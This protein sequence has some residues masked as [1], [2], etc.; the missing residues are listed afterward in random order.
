MKICVGFLSS[1]SYEL[2]IASTFL[3]PRALLYTQPLYWATCNASLLTVL[4]AS[5][6]NKENA[7]LSLF[8]FIERV[9]ESWRRGTMR[10]W[11]WILLWKRDR[12][13]SSREHIWYHTDFLRFLSSLQYLYSLQSFKAL[14]SVFSWGIW[15]WSSRITRWRWRGKLSTYRTVWRKARKR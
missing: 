15:M 6:L 14:S 9:R 10:C 7:F 8:V 12:G 5:S 4:C 11:I 3:W 2:S 13:S 1:G